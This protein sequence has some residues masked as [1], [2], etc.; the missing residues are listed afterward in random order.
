MAQGIENKKF[1]CKMNKIS[2]IIK[3]SVS[4]FVQE[5]DE[6]SINSRSLLS[7]GA[8]IGTGGTIAKE[9]DDEKGFK[10]VISLFIWFFL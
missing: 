3:F 10:S 7:L 5:I 9:G 8:S 6:N 2:V 1:T 4:L